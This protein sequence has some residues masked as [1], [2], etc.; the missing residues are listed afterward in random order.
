[1]SKFENN[2]A[3]GSVIKQLLL[4]AAPFLLSNFIQSVYSVADMI[5]VGQF[6]G[7]NAMSG[8]NIGSQV[9]LLVTNFVFGLSVGATVLIG[10]YLGA[11]DKKSMRQTIGTLFTSLMVLA[12]AIT[13]V[14]HVL[15]RPLL[16]LIQTPKESFQDAL[17]Y[18]TVTNLGNIF[19]FGY[20]A[21]SA[22]MRGMGDSK[23]PLIFVSVACV[24][25][26]GLDLL[27]VAVFGM[28]A[29]GAALATVFSQAV[30]MVL[31][32]I[33]LKRNDFIFD[34]KLASFGFHK[35]KLG[36]LLKVGVPSCVQNVAVS[37]S[38]LF[39]TAMVNT[40]GA[41]ASA[42]VGAVGKFNGFAI[43]PALAMSSSISAMA[44]HN[45]G[46]GEEKRAVR[47]M[48]YG[49]GIAFGIS[50]VVFALAQLFPE[51]IL[52]VFGG[53]ESMIA[54]GITYMR[55]FSFDFLVVPIVFC[56][57]GLFIGSGHTLFSLINGSMSSVLVRIPMAYLFGF[58][59]EWGLGGIG[60]GGPMAS[61]VAS[62]VAL[63][64]FFTGR[65]K[66]STI[67]KQA[68]TTE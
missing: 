25:N 43:L 36:L 47:T 57:N 2:L 48:Q 56:M 26:I 23:N 62:L 63:I 16:E 27:L 41:E 3:K 42:A 29:M 1:M 46:A 61:A 59:F 35:E 39:L 28:G 4:F 60:L 30:S 10:Q 51:A 52:Q 5:I 9:T 14:L 13:L 37:V 38:F 58:V 44:A 22:V 33:Y 20:N 45:I 17:D 40:L 8:V 11:G 19:I 12:F 53:D 67:L 15:R 66:K 32:I 64:Y 18:F 7:T 49:M 50:A 55:S 68:P 54:F 65:W 34:F 21:L 24:T 6:A 31:C